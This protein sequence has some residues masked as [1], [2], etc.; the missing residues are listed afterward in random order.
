ME[1]YWDF[2]MEV[3]LYRPGKGVNGGDFLGFLME[4]MENN[5]LR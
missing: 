5:G 3:K 4:G 2:S 1:S